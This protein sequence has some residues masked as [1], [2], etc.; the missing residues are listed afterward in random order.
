MKK[1]YLL[2]LL[3]SFVLTGEKQLNA[4][5]K[6][7][8]FD[9][10]LFTGDDYDGDDDDGDDF[11]YRSFS[12]RHAA[13]VD[14]GAEEKVNK[15]FSLDQEGKTGLHWI[16]NKKNFLPRIVAMMQLAKDF[17]KDISSLVKIQDANGKTALHYAAKHPRW[18]VIEE[19]MNAGADVDV[20]DNQG[21]TP[22]QLITEKLLT[23]KNLIKSDSNI[24]VF[25]KAIVI[26]Q[27]LEF[28][29]ETIVNMQDYTG[30]TLLHYAA[31]HGCS[32]IVY[33]LINATQFTGFYVA[34]MDIRD[35]QGKTPLHYAREF[36]HSEVT[37]KLVNAHCDQS[38]VDN[39]GLKPVDYAREFAGKK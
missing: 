35:S 17:G 11:E 4:V 12:F 32:K 15:F 37:Q 39:R 7:F 14:H 26:A 5:K 24:L 16:A 31:E 22:K 2:L 25:K 9:G 27:R 36:G 13:Y 1:L 33:E 20:S 29:V 21:V 19:L 10:Q 3:S 6:A 28:S 38:I 23:M 34:T 18:K 30:K 8:F